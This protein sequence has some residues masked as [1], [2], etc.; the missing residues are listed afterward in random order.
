M[1]YEIMNRKAASKS[2]LEPDAPLTAI[3]SI[4][5][6]G[7][8]LNTFHP[9]DWIVDILELQFN[10]MINEFPNG[11]TEAHAQLIVDFAKKHYNCVQR[12]IIHCEYGQ[13]RS[14]GITV[15]LCE[16]FERTDNGIPKDERYIPNWYCHRLVKNYLSG[17]SDDV[18]YCVLLK[19]GKHPYLV[20]SIGEVA[21]CM[22]TRKSASYNI[23]KDLLEPMKKG[24]W[25]W[26][27][28]TLFYKYAGEFDPDELVKI[29]EKEG[30]NG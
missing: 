25:K 5:D 27:D 11:M 29:K 23:L 30:L 3:I 1:I 9:Q 20:K 14:A 24:E 22:E 2:T 16:H 26:V 10:D 19:G 21:C 15:A 4:T 18:R 7:D 8:E 17:N 28:G 12:F 6:K 13:S